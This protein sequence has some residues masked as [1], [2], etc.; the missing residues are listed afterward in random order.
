MGLDKEKTEGRW[1]WV[2]GESGQG[3]GIVVVA[4]WMLS[5]RRN[6][7]PYTQIYAASGWDSLVCHPHVLNL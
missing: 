6:L 2:R 3:R 1:N 7:V 4:A 5:K